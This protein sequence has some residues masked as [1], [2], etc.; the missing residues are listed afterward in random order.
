MSELLT[1]I[2]IRRSLAHFTSFKM[3]IADLSKPLA[4]LTRRFLA[5]VGRVSAEIVASCGFSRCW[6]CSNYQEITGNG[7]ARCS[8]DPVP[9]MKLPQAGFSWKPS[10]R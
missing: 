4:M 8:S 2:P 3:T 5:W 1:F 9:G 10:C 7:S 6:A